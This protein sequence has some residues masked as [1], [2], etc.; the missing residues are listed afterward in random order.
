[1]AASHGFEPQQSDQSHSICSA[2]E[3]FKAREA[4]TAVGTRKF[5]NKVE[6][7]KFHNEPTLVGVEKLVDFPP[8]PLGS[9]F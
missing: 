1:L 9:A 2:V 6:I 4:Q 7:S 8:G 5:R 3:F